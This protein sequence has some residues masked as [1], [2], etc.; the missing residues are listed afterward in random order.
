M[1]KYL[2]VTLYQFGFK[3]LAVRRALS[4]P[5]NG[6]PH[7]DEAKKNAALEFLQTQ[8]VYDRCG[9]CQR[10]LLPKDP[11]TTC[12]QEVLCCQHGCKELA[13]QE[14]Y[15]QEHWNYN[16]RCEGCKGDRR[17]CNDC[18]LDKIC[19]ICFADRELCGGH[20]AESDALLEGVQYDSEE[21][22]MVSTTEIYNR[23]YA[24]FGT[25]E[26]AREAVQMYPGDF[27]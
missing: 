1:P 16:F 7:Y 8:T 4:V 22:D 20:H 18:I 23:A 21:D 13:T 3:K 15:C 19:D 27:A 17:L 25:A 9:Q 5:Q 14:D 10:L 6:E 12:E 2:F 24:H 11:H 26:Q